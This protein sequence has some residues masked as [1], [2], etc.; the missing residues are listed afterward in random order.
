MA[1]HTTRQNAPRCKPGDLAWVVHSTNALLIGRLVV[2]EKWG[3][4]DRWDVT[5]I[6]SPSFGLEFGTGRPIIGHKTAFRDSSL[7]PLAGDDNSH[8]RSIRLESAAL[9]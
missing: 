7:L 5:L 8:N 9:G 4:N 3:Q 1:Q 6:G 2:V